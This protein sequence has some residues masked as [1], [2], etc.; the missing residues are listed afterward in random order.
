LKDSKVGYADLIKLVN[1]LP[2]GYRT[3]FNLAIFDEM[4]HEEIAKECGISVG[5][6]RSQLHK[7]R[8]RLQSLITFHYGKLPI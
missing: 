3:V 8:K 5:T 1:F 2:E 4:S 6:S 7:A